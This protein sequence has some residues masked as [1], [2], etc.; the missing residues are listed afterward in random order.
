MSFG[1]NIRSANG[2]K[3][4]W[5]WLLTLDSTSINHEAVH[6]YQLLW[7]AFLTKPCLILWIKSLTSKVCVCSSN[8]FKVISLFDFVFYALWLNEV[9]IVGCNFHYSIEVWV[10]VIECYILTVFRSPF[11]L[12]DND[13]LIVVPLFLVDGWISH[14][15]YARLVV[16]YIVV[17]WFA[18]HQ[19]WRGCTV[20]HQIRR[21]EWF[22]VFHR[23]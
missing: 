22:D 3:M 5:I 12:F 14:G 21:F 9:F 1:N 18:E 11:F 7:T 15:W 20:D 23:W 10:R 8:I 16:A 6:E 17:K 13:R 19:N 2:S 4:S